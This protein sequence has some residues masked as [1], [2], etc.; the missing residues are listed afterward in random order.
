MPGR[1]GDGAFA[2]GAHPIRTRDS[3]VLR[4]GALGAALLAVAGLGFG[5]EAKPPKPQDE[6]F[7]IAFGNGVTWQEGEIKVIF[8]TGEVVLGKADF[9]LTASRAMAWQRADQLEE[10]YAEGNV[11]FRQ[12]TQK[13]RAERLYF[14][15]AQNRAFIVDLRMR[16]TSK[17]IRNQS[18]YFTASEARMVAEGVLEAEDLSI[19]TCTYGVPHY[20]ISVKGG[21]LEGEGRRT[22]KGRQD[23][24]PY[25]DWSLDIDRMYPELM[26]APLLFIP[27]LVLGPWVREFPLRGLAYG[28]SSRFGNSV[29]TEWGARIRRPDPEG[30]LRSWGDLVAEVDWRQTRGGALGLDLKYDWPGYLGF[31]DTYFLKDQG[32][33][34]DVSFDQRLETED[35][36]RREERGRAHAFHRHELDDQWS[37]ELEAH[38]LSDRSL[39]EEFFPRE[40]RED[41]DPE[42]A[43]YLRWADGNAGAYLYERHRLNDFQT[44]NE[45]LP[46]ADFHLLH[47]PP[48]HNPSQDLYVTHRTD[49]VHIRRRFAD[50]LRLESAETWRL[51]LSTEVS[52]PRDL[53]ILQVSPFVQSRLTL[54]EDDL[55]GETELRSLWTAGGRISTQFHGTYPDAR[56]DLVGLRGLRHV[57]EIEVRYANTVDSNLE[58]GEVFPFEEVDQ[59]GEFEE[60]AL[61]LRARALTKDAAGKPFE[62]LS[63]AMAIEHYPDSDRDTRGARADN[64]EPPFHWIALAPRASTGRFERR[65]WSNLHYQVAFQPR[66]FFSLAG[67]GE[68]N[69]VSRHEEVR[70]LGVTLSPLAGL[71]ASTSQT[72]VR[73]LTDAY[74]FAVSWTLTEK[75]MVSATAQYDF[76]IDEYLAQGLVVSRDYHDFLLQAVVERDFGRD[77]QRFYLTFVPKFLGL[78]KFAPTGARRDKYD[79]YGG[80]K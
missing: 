31:V 25:Q 42:T 12:G 35:P 17:D 78:G 55:E 48:F 53:G 4:A 18:F 45:Y 32:R 73:G 8:M 1:W 9:E 26:G 10:I 49:L 63:G 5:Q 14:N 30:K 39:R 44:Q 68:Y 40:F 6:P 57:A 23:I 62:F 21:R 71:T 37:Y 75:W 29:L 66:T 22:P 79:Q 2:G 58:A 56:W 38:Y 77:E 61:R 72:F 51:D 16:G 65:H 54:F 76:K 41:K 36:L 33:D 80:Q 7:R 50:D 20:H 67:A 74:S 59:I 19:S 34:L 46:R 27:G 15:F 43:A 11:V 24:W 28:R 69:P 13:M 52:L 3:G 60:V 64:S 70:E 47:A